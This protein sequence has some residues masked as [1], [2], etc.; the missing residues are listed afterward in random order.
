M[1]DLRD[2]GGRHSQGIAWIASEQLFAL[3]SQDEPGLMRLMDAN[4]RAAGTRAIVPTPQAV[5]AIDYVP[6]DSPAFP[7]HLVL[8]DPFK[9]SI[10]VLQR[11]G[12]VVRE[13]RPRAPVG[14]ISGLAY[15][16]PGRLLVSALLDVR[17]NQVWTLDFDGNILSGPMR[18][19]AVN[20]L[21][22]IDVDRNGRVVA[23]DFYSG[24]IEFLDPDTLQAI[25]G[26]VRE[27]AFGLGISFLR[28]IA[29]DSAQQR[30]LVSDSARHIGTTT[31]PGPVWAVTP[32]LAVA[33]PFSF[34][35]VCGN[36]LTLRM[37]YLP[38]ERRSVIISRD[39]PRALL[40]LEEG[41]EIAETIDVSA[42]GRPVNVAYLSS[43]QQFA[44]RTVEGGPL[45]LHFVSRSGSLVRTLD[46][47]P[48]GLDVIGP[49]T[50][51]NP[52]H[53]SGGELLVASFQGQAVRIDLN[54]NLT[55]S[56]DL[57]STLNVRTVN[58][59]ATVDSGPRADAFA[60]VDNISAELVVFQLP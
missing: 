60:L 33:S 18:V 4:G 6:A 10:L 45:L 2:V 37:S 35:S 51:F 58:D 16:P 47:A 23:G 49:L 12:Q 44:L 15:A 57:A 46:L 39:R 54:G 53:S 48:T 41:G 14:A 7:D 9:A 32:D 59:L 26:E 56:Y 24:R 8:V 36:V 22:G 21:E 19:V 1:F 29:W 34:P 25:P 13:I 42:L 30:F 43:V 27:N 17:L 52:S 50:A 11:G 38:D 20:S 5:E 31:F 55:A 3:V 40:L 28:G